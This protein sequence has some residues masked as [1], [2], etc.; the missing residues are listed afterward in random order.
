MKPENSSQTPYV[1]GSKGFWF[2]FNTANLGCLAISCSQFVRS[3][4]LTA[5]TVE[6]EDFRVQKA[7][8]LDP[9]VSDVFVV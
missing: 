7:A 9:A 4:G 3:V 6:E 8:D 1:V 2:G 5:A